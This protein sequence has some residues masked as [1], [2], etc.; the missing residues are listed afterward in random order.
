MT[1]VE[2]SNSAM[3]CEQVTTSKEFCG[4][5]DETIILEET[6]VFEAEWVIELVQDNFLILNMINMLASN[7]LVLLHGFDSEL[8]GGVVPQPA[9]SDKSKGT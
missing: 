7:D 2:V 5:I 6:V 1:G 9:D 4:E 8:S 3:V